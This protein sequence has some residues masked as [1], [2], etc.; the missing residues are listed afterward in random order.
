M[1]IDFTRLPP[2]RVL[3]G[4]LTPE[5]AAQL[6]GQSDI[7]VDLE[8]MGLNPLRDRLCLIQMMGRSGPA[9]F[10]RDP[11]PPCPHLRSVFEEPGLRKVFHYA[12]MDVAFLMHRLGIITRNIYCTRTASK[13]VRTYSDSHGLKDVVLEFLGFQLD[14]TVKHTDWANDTLTDQ[15]LRYALQDVAV[16]LPIK[17]LLAPMLDREGRTALAEECFT[18]IPILAKLDLMDFERLFEHH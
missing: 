15:Q 18:V 16:L 11:R 4:D 14:K 2:P 12:R 13:L 9:L 7:G 8:M 17:D 3:T 6:L 1:D 5:L 10:V